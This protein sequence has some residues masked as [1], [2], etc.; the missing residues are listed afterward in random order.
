MPS[1]VIV[2]TITELQVDGSFPVTAKCRSPVGAGEVCS[3][4]A[5]PGPRQ[6]ER[7]VFISHLIRGLGF[8]LHPFLRG[9]LFFYGLDFHHLGPNSIL[10]IATYITF[11]EAFL[12]IKPHFGLWLKIFC[13]KPHSSGSMLAGC[14][15]AMVSKINKISWPEGTFIETVR[16]W[17]QEWFHLADQ[18]SGD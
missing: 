5:I 8:P 15:G 6:G 14:G 10:H 3:A 7:V 18:S 13:I 4:S 12:R 17:Q 9:L 1:N 2:G 11:C 16:L